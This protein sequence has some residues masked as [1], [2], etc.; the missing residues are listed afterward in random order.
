VQSGGVSAAANNSEL[1]DK[2]EASQ[3]L[4]REEIDRVKHKLSAEEMARLLAANSETFGRKTAFSQAKYLRKKRA[5][6]GRSFALLRGSAAVVCAALLAKDSQR[7]L[8]LRPDVLGL[9]LALAN[10]R[11]GA[12]TLVVDGCASLVTAAAAERLGGLGRVL[13]PHP[14]SNP[15]NAALRF[16]DLSPEERASVLHFPFAVIGALAAEREPA[17]QGPA[18]DAPAA[19]AAKLDRFAEARRL[20]RAGCHSLVVA[21]NGALSPLFDAVLPLL[22]PGASLAVYSPYCEPLAAAA[23]V[24]RDRGLVVNGRLVDL[25]T[26]DQQVL[27]ARTHPVVRMNAA[28]GF[29]WSAIYCGRAQPR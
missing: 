11:A 29:V 1:Y 14:G 13:A 15:S 10:V 7:V 19:P 21:Y 28:S 22:Q 2:G 18:P 8:G 9:L 26:R 27:P 23:E 20:L 5:K 6:Y 3:R 17:A 4:T 24:L 12:A 16:V 25:F